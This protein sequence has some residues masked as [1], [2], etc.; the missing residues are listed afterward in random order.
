MLFRCVVLWIFLI[1][2]VYSRE[3]VEKGLAERDANDYTSD[4]IT[5]W[6][7][8]TREIMS[9]VLEGFYVKVG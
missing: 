1:Q 9:R 5:S 3:K 8:A 2:E 7:C 4:T 6:A